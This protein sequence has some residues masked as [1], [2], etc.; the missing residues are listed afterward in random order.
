MTTLEEAYAEA[1]IKPRRAKP[2]H[3]E[4]TL[5]T[6]LVGFVREFV[7]CE[8]EFAAHD[9][10]F[11][12]TG[13]QHLFEA[14]RGVRKDWLDT[15]LVLERRQLVPATTFRCELK[16]GANKPSDGQDA[17]IRRLNALGHPA[18]WANSIDGWMEAAAKA[19]APFRPGALARARYLDEW[20]R[21]TFE[22]PR[23][24]AKA[25]RARTPRPSS[26]ALVVATKFQR[27]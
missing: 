5:Q 18:A 6:K 27:P 20:L 19:G 13:K 16:W 2:R 14:E 8:H 23:T 11:D 7:A 26:R 15:E 9:R 10:S 24:A 21:A 3:P 22:K 12:A 4:W 1:G 17:L 25:G